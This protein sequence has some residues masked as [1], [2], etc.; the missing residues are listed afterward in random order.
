V[1]RKDEIEAMVFIA[2]AAVM[3]VVAFWTVGL[4]GR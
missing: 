4:I 2:I 3:L 1:W